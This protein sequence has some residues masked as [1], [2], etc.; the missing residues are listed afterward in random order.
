MDVS[1]LQIC[2]LIHDFNNGIKDE[3]G[4]SF[5]SLC[6]INKVAKHNRPM[7]SKHFP[8][9]NNFSASETRTSVTV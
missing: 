7:Q 9:V 3:S 6:N 2:Q 8:I 1:S 5:G 4:V